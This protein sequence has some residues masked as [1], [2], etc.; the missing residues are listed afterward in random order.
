MLFCFRTIG[1]KKTITMRSRLAVGGFCRVWRGARA[2]PL[3]RWMPPMHVAGTGEL[4]ELSP[5]VEYS[6]NNSHTFRCV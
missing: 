6:F 5:V 3:D 4:P 1:R 2:L